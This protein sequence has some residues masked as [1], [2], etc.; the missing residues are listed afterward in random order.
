MREPAA[1]T[2][3]RLLEVAGPLPIVAVPVVLA[4]RVGVGEDRVGFIDLF[5]LLFRCRV[6]VVDVWVM[7]AREFTEGATDVFL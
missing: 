5:E 4:P 3:A 6:T 7:F 2:E 1:A